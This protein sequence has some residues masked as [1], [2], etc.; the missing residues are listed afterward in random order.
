MCTLLLQREFGES[1]ESGDLV[2]QQASMSTLHIVHVFCILLNY[3]ISILIKG[4][5]SLC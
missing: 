2:I 4:K 5:S 1:G 3:Q